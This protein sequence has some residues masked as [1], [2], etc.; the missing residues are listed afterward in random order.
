MAITLAGTATNRTLLGMRV[1]T[2]METLML[3]TRLSCFSRVRV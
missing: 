3:V 1:P 2:L